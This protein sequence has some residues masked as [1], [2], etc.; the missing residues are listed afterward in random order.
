MANEVEVREER[1]E[2]ILSF[3]LAEE[4]SDWRRRQL[5]AELVRRRNVPGC[6][7]MPDEELLRRVHLSGWC[8]DHPV[9][10]KP[11]NSGSWERVFCLDFEAPGF[12]MRARRDDGQFVVI[13]PEGFEIETRPE[14]T[15]RLLDERVHKMEEACVSV[16][17]K[18]TWLKDQVKAVHEL[19]A[20]V[21]AE[22][23]RHQQK[24]GASCSPTTPKPTD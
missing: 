8:S 13:D 14:R 22:L 23:R 18:L 12:R 21:H 9:W 20:R 19:R 10:V 16:E 11:K 7:R 15:M 24:G 17:K 4:L 2:D 5:E 6:E 3:T 1:L